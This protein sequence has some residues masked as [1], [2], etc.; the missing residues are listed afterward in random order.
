MV[1]ALIT[2]E[3]QQEDAVVGEVQTIQ[4]MSPVPVEDFLLATALLQLI[5][6][7]PSLLTETQ[8]V[9]TEAY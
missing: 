7:T 1:L 2:T 4:P 9:L 8:D 5:T 6:N 3:T